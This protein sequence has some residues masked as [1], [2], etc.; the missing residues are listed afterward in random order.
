MASKLAAQMAEDDWAA[1]RQVMPILTELEV[2][3]VEDDANAQTG[4]CRC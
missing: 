2:L 4:S 1:Q 3:T